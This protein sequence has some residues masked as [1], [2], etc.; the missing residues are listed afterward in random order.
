M[1]KTEYWTTD[2]N[3]ML[4]TDSIRLFNE[5]VLNDDSFRLFSLRTGNL[6]SDS[7][8]RDF[9][10][11]NL[12]RFD[13]RQIAEH[14][15]EQI[16]GGLNNF[17]N[18]CRFGL[19]IRRDAIMNL[20]VL[21]EWEERKKYTLAP[22]HV[23]EGVIIYSE[24]ADKKWYFVRN[25]KYYGW[26]HKDSVVLCHDRDKLI[27][28]V[29]H[30]DFLIVTGE[31]ME[32]RY[33]DCILRYDLGDRISLIGEN[34]DTFRVIVYDSDD[35]GYVVKKEGCIPKTA[36]VHR[37]FLR[38]TKKN[39]LDE[40]FKCLGASYRWG[41]GDNGRDCS[42]FVMEIFSLFGILFPKYSGWQ[43]SVPFKG[44][45]LTSVSNKGEALDSLPTG[46]LLFTNGHVMIYLGNRDDNHYVLHNAGSF[47]Q[48]GGKVYHQYGVTVSSLEKMFMMKGEA[49]VD[50]LTKALMVHFI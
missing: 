9:V 20:P 12:N 21:G 47:C 7:D 6:P 14:Y 32:V 31:S 4:D 38:L 25:E 30:D 28:C 5:K 11:Y 36:D 18:G 46:S 3:L 15:T 1:L 10:R 16:E 27:E 49:F 43:A 39:L 34:S 45:D 26:V 2:D 33:E 42:S 35:R 44:F 50:S 22:L 13:N 19:C 24:T 48:K 17:G 37:G 29:M 41:G 8:R 40:C 23:N